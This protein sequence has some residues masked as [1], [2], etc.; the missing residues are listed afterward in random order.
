MNNRLNNLPFP[1]S[2]IYNE[3]SDACMH[4]TQAKNRCVRVCTG[5]SNSQF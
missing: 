2:N 3:K 4:V 5:L 1:R